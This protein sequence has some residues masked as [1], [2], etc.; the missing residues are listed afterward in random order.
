MAFLQVE[1]FSNV[2]GKAM[3][4]NVLLPQTA[5]TQVGVDGKEVTNTYPTLY[6]LHGMSDNHS[7]WTRYT[8]IERY[9]AAK[10]IAVVMPNADL[11][12]YSDIVKNGGEYFTFIADEL[13]SIC[14]SFFPRMSSK[15]EETFIGGLSMGGYGAVK[16]ALS[17]P[18][19]FSHAISLSGVLD[20]G[21]FARE[22][23]RQEI[24]KL[25]FKD[26]EAVPESDHDI[27]V[28]ADKLLQS[29]KELPRLYLWCGT[30]DYLWYC[31][32]KATEKLPQMGFDVTHSCS[33]GSHGWI[34]WDD[35]IEKALDWLPL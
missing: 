15:R 9:A 23:S 30:E 28:L 25:D 16:I 2:L 22:C 19:T 6:L 20:V 26:I 12:F 34:W 29:G 32:E 3:S 5:P 11:S 17:R 7:A 21:R 1:F 13:P 18:D 8:A 4:M 10:G 24:M 35:Q 14:R 33:P 31:H 27:F